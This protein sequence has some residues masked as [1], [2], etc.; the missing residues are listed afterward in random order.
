[1]HLSTFYFIW[2]TFIGTL[3]CYDPDNELT[4]FGTAA[5]NFNEAVSTMSDANIIKK[6]SLL[7][8]GKLRL[9]ANK[10]KG[11]LQAAGPL[12][13]VISIVFSEDVEYKRYVI[14]RLRI[15]GLK[16]RLFFRHKEIMNEFKKLNDR[17]DRVELKLDEQTRLL[18]LVIQQAHLTNFLA[19]IKATNGI[20]DAFVLKN[21][22][23]H[24]HELKNRYHS[25]IDNIVGLELNI[26]QYF[27]KFMD[28]HGNFGALFDIYTNIA[29]MLTKLKLAFGVGCLQRCRTNNHTDSHCTSSCF[30]DDPM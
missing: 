23:F 11:L 5:K 9:V 6:T 15:Q 24:F 25:I 13:I 17:F 10:L 21:S 3:H 18:I 26:G 7:D 14:L 22:S 16:R 1:M 2:A 27:E 30:E 20:Y 28:V 12:A 29:G 19:P 8:S 4:N